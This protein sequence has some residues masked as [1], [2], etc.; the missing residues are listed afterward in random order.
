ME[1]TMIDFKVAL[2]TTLLLVDGNPGQLYSRALSMKI[3]G[4]SVVTAASPVDAIS[5]MNRCSFPRVDVAV[6]DYHMPVVNGWVLAA[7]LKSDYPDLKIV[8]YSGILDVAEYEMSCVDAF[9][10][11]GEG[12][13]SLLGKI[14][15]LGKMDSANPVV[16]AVE[17]DARLHAAN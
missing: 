17:R 3:C 7:Y 14:I 9:L 11:K 2:R 10:E 1:A 8:L 6:I 5:I 13:G 4:F 15:E 16:Y 12:I